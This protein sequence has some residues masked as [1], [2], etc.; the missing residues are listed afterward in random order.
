MTTTVTVWTATHTG[1]PSFHVVTDT[2]RDV[3]CGARLV[4][5]LAPGEHLFSDA[6][7]DPGSPTVYRV[8]QAQVTVA[9]ASVGS[10]AVTDMHGRRAVRVRQLGE[11]AD[12][13]DPR[14]SLFEPSGRPDPVPRW[15]L[16]ASS[17]SGVLPL[18]VEGGAQVAAM[19]ALV[20]LRSPLIVIH[21]PTVCETVE[22]D[23]PGC[24]LVAVSGVVTSS[25][26]SVTSMPRRL[27]SVPY[28]RLASSALVPPAPVV[29]WGEWAE[30]GTGWR[31]KSAVQ[32]A[33]DLAGMP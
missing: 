5:R 17:L 13:L 20:S 4:A 8:G 3:M 6:L 9:R 30:L 32:V 15:G 10:H 2:P 16:S 26:D 19:Q 21:D 14:V 27:F 31:T 25:R 33:R 11:D 24:R 23:I 22:C 18:K 29:T 12:S 1:L 7:A 28:R